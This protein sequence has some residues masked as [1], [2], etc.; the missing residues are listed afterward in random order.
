MHEPLRPS[1]TI[2]GAGLGGALLAVYLGQAGYEVELLE[3]RPDP[4]SSALS[5][6]RS[7][8]LALSTR[9]LHALREVGLADEILRIAIPMRGR[10]LHHL[11]GHQFYQPYDKDPA[12]AIHSVSRAGLNLALIEAARRLPNVRMRFNH[13][14]V[15]ADLDRPS[16]RFLDENGGEYESRG[17][18]LIGFD[19]AFSAIRGRMQRQDGFDYSQSYLAHGYK[20]LHIPPASDGQFAMDPNALHI[21]PRKRFMM[22]ALPNP[23]CSFTVTCFW[24]HAGPNSFS[25][26]RTPEQVGPYFRRHFPDAATMM[27]TLVEDYEKNPIGALAT[28]RC[29]PWHVHDKVLILGDAAHAIVPFYGQGMNC[30]F[31][32]CTVFMQC[33]REHAPDWSRVLR[34]CF[35]LR[36]HDADTLADLA[37]HN[38]V[39]MRD[40]SGSTWFQLRKKLE[41]TLHRRLP[42]WYT[43]LYTM[44]SFTRI[45]YSQ[46]VMRARRQDRTV[47]V[48]GVV[49]LALIIVAL[50]SVLRA[51]L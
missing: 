11:D 7:I 45:P 6:G 33:I 51:M 13:R 23:D 40:H 4:H 49:L 50:I 30:A 24:P 25:E 27:P 39:E 17:E 20:E 14:C 42:G 8:N 37:L 32:D 35:E 3:R 26:I 15:D 12:R 31:E 9:G 22:I 5:G 1:F 19:G 38:F 48:V 44:V 41:R 10:R 34:R 36:K 29:A 18:I 21:W 43:P 16:A 47:L 2:V 28:I 46:A